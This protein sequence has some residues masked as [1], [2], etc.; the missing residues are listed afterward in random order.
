MFAHAGRMIC[1]NEARLSEPGELLAKKYQLL[2]VDRHPISSAFDQWSKVGTADCVRPDQATDLTPTSQRERSG[3]PNRHV[4]ARYSPVKDQTI[5][6]SFTGGFVARPRH[7]NDVLP[8]PSDGP[9]SMIST[10][11]SV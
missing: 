8:L 1:F 7:S 4:A 9:M 6:A 2:H 11:S 10:E 5:F 3:D